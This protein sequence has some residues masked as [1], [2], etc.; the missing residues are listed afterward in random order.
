MV[1]TFADDPCRAT[2]RQQ[3]DAKSGECLRPGIGPCAAS[4]EKAGDCQYHKCGFQ[5]ANQP[6]NL[7][8]VPWN[9][10]STARR[11]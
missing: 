7:G 5:T 6:H 2:S 4:A 3:T 10:L 8:I 11:T 9:G 1:S